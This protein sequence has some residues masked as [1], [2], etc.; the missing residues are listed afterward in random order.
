MKKNLMQ[1]AKCKICTFVG[2]A[3]APLVKQKGEWAALSMLLR[4]RGYE[5]GP[6]ALCDLIAA[7][8]PNAPQP[9]KQNLLDAEFDTNRRRFPDWRADGVRYDKF[10]RFYLIAQQAS[11]FL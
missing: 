9:T 6:S 1:N 4:E 2:A 11:P 10:R 8:V 5:I 7:E 3:C